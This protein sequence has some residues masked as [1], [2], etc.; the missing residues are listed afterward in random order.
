MSLL[1]HRGPA[2]R[3]SARRKSRGGLVQQAMTAVRSVVLP[4]KEDG[5]SRRAGAAGSASAAVAGL[6]M[7]CVGLGYVLGNLVPWQAAQAAEAGLRV[8]AD[9]ARTGRKPGPI[10]EQEDMRPLSESYFLTANYGDLAAGSVAARAL[11]QA[12][13][14]KARVREFEFEKQGQ[15]VRVFSVVVY[16]DG[17]R[18]QEDVR[19]RL[20]AVPAPDA[21]FDGFRKGTRGWPLV[22]QLR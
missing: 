14:A 3:G 22:Q 17:T 6:A 13:I 2:Y 7:L 8:E 10:G 1:A 11:R 21:A 5:G 19:A 12:G 16:F 20:L 4:R 9:K 15:P 18:E